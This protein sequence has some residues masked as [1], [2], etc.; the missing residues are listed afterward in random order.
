MA[1]Y[2]NNRINYIVNSVV[3]LIWPLGVL[4]LSLKDFTSKTARFG[5]SV[6]GF[7]IGYTMVTKSGMDGSRI[8]NRFLE[9]SNA[10]WSDFKVSILGTYVTEGVNPDIY[11][12]SMTYFISRF[13][14]NTH[15]FFGILSFIY[16][17]VVVGFIREI[18][19]LLN[20]RDLIAPKRNFFFYVL[21]ASFL[22]IYPLSGGANAVRFPLATFFFFYTIIFYLK[23]RRVKYIV[24]NSLTFLIHWSFIPVVLLFPVSLVLSKLKSNKYVIVVF[25]MLFA[26]SN[27]ISENIL[28][29]SI[30]EGSTIENRVDT[31]T[32][33]TYVSNMAVSLESK[34][35][36]VK[37][38]KLLPLY[39]AVLVLVF[40]SIMGKRFVYSKITNYFFV[41]S[42]VLGVLTFVVGNEAGLVNNR[43]V[44][45]LLISTL[46][47]LGLA[48]RDNARKRGIQWLLWIY[49][50]IFL[51]QCYM[52]FRT[53]FEVLT[54]T[55]Y[56][57][58]IFIANLTENSTPIIDLIK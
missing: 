7:F 20:V 41:L 3:F 43:F 49:L 27:I 45:L 26:A 50:P 4:F 32:K 25:V 16:F 44:K 9:S 12:S 57:G 29:L 5:F 38:S 37:L 52:I 42:L 15:L 13:S 39:F 31:F 23:Q 8:G 2:A 58:N 6:V 55:T 14:A 30:L 10:S 18:Y 19:F 56:L 47:F 36:N 28:K 33:E 22:F 11:L 48:W 34:N 40:F 53:D 54:L 24:L 35:I 1:V 21:L 46:V 51:L 17:Y